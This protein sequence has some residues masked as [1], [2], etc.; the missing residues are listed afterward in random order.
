[1]NGVNAGPP[2]FAG[3]VDPEEPK[4]IATRVMF[5]EAREDGIV[6]QS[7]FWGILGLVAAV[8]LVQLW[9]RVRSD[10][11]HV[12]AVQAANDLATGVT[13]DVAIRAT[14]QGRKMPRNAGWVQSLRGIELKGGYAQKGAGEKNNTDRV[15]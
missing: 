13:K 3:T 10:W 2:A 9:S 15:V 14:F 12:D 7:L 4:Y 11:V 6:V 5:I 1:M 8:L